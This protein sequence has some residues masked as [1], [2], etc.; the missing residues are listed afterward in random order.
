MSRSFEQIAERFWNQP[1][2]GEEEAVR[3]QLFMDD[4]I[5]K[6]HLD[7]T[8]AA[9]LDGVKTVFDGGAGSGRLTI[10]LAQQGYRVT[11]FDISRPMIATA[12]ERAREAEVAE[13][14]TFTE[15]ALTDLSAYPDQ[16]F[17][18]VLCFDAPLS[19]VYPEHQTV[20]QDLVR[21]ARK[22]VI[23]SVSSRLGYLPYLFNPI[24]KLQYLVDE[25]SD[26]P[27]VQW[28]VQTAA[29]KEAGWAPNFELFD[30][31]WASGLME[32][33]EAILA[34]Y[35]EG[36]APWPVNYGFMPDELAGLLT[37]AG[38]T[39][40]DLAGPGALSRSIPRPI[41]Q[42]LVREDREAFLDR[43]Y[44]FDSQPWVAGLGKDNLVG[45]GRKG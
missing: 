11:H 3:E 14:I 21:I 22:A 8:I 37:A 44:Q 40:V 28:F 25:T 23:V 36:K 4:I 13:R 7:R 9:H 33:P 35:E 31:Y 6:A 2:K 30:R 17:D 45:I 26:D 16:S 24:Q 41:L 15:G 5:Q 29:A 39:Q 18:L 38:L 20:I 1:T 34:R 32:A 27:L 43:C 19:Y 42:R 10:P 12:Q